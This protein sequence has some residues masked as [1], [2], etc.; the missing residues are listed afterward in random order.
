MT[1]RYLVLQLLT[2]ANIRYCIVY[3]MLCI[4]NSTVYG[5]PLERGDVGK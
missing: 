3:Y 1:F 2:K 5:L 4:L